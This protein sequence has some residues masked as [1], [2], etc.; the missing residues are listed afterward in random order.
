[1]DFC[2]P[3]YSKYLSVLY[4][5]H[6]LEKGRAE[7]I[8]EFA[9]IRFSPWF[10][11]PDMEQVHLFQDEVRTFPV[12]MCRI[13]NLPLDFW[14]A[15]SMVPALNRLLGTRTVAQLAIERLELPVLHV[16]QLAK[17]LTSPLARAGMDYEYLE[18]LGDSFLK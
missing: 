12:S 7:A 17:A 11:G 15:F 9:S 4:S 14:N 16:D 8:L 13:S 5:Y 6:G 3:D 2:S 10:L 18:T 1:M